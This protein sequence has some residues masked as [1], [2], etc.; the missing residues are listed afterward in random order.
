[1]TT[2]DA[3]LAERLKRLRNGGQSDRYHH[4]EP[5]VNSRLD[6]IQAAILR[7]RLPWLPAWTRQR[8]ERA[9]RY[10]QSLARA[11]AV[12]V[13]LEFDPGH[14][15]HLFVV[16]ARERERLR[17]HLAER[18]IETLIHYPVPI[19]RQPA[20]AGVNPAPCPRA[21][22]VCGELLSLPL[23]PALVPEAVDNVA[24]AIEAFGD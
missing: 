7:A 4:E 11:D 18:G 3:A 23:H 2:A 8:R 14:V 13:P 20:M 10:R 19:S 21:D 12:H 6:E 9:A 16:H 17:L 5:G 15:Y 22:Q 24:A 1:V